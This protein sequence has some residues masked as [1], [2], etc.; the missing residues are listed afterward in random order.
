MATK[1]TL[2]TVAGITTHTATAPNGTVST[3]TKVRYGTDL[4]RLVKMLNNPKKIEDQTLGICLAPVRVD[5]VEL[6]TGMLKVDAIK[7]LA[8]HPDFQSAADQAVLQEALSERQPKAPR[9][10]KTPKAPKVKA[11][12][13]KPSIDSIKSRAKKQVTPEQIV[14][15]ALS[16][17]VVGK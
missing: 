4:I 7:F 6:P 12:K 11:A 8:T 3:R 9:T 14:A 17:E 16:A 2:F 1:D 13:A 10:P 15:A 5:F